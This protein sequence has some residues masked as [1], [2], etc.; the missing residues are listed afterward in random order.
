M[1]LPSLYRVICASEQQKSGR[2][3]TKDENGCAAYHRIFRFGNMPPLREFAAL[4]AKAAAALDC[5]PPL[6]A[7][8]SGNADCLEGLGKLQQA[9]TRNVS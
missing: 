4:L 1:I 5:V 6:S 8:P 2:K 7:L 3:P 9:S